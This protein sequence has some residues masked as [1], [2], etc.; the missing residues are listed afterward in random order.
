MRA[1]K[2]LAG[3]GIYTRKE[4]K[5]FFK[6]KKVTINGEIVTDGS[7]HIDEKS[8][9]IML[10]NNI[11]T[12][13]KYVYLMMNKPAGYIS[14]TEDAKDPT[15]I[16]LLPEEY[17][18]FHPFPV[19]R[20]DKDTVGLLLLT[21]DGELA[22]KLLSP[23]K[24]VPKIYLAKVEKEI[25]DKDIKAFKEGIYI[26]EGDYTTMPGNLEIVEK[27]DNPLC[28]V[29]ICE[30]KFHQVKR[31]FEKRNNKVLFLKRITFAGLN[32]DEKL[33]E[34]QVRQLTDH[35]LKIIGKEKA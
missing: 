18:H 5:D 11:V 17:M 19:G 33:A 35:E 21:N 3:Q 28:K 14:A 13:Q 31:M 15:V 9:I 6:K 27:G 20:L 25:N 7:V 26:P 4:V 1:D 29:T 34:G 12:Y 30:G 22:H 16:D 23:K 32:L 2:F 10:D 24:K 8:D